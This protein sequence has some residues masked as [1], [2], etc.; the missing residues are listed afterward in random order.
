MRIK[1]CTKVAGEPHYTYFERCPDGEVY[2]RPYRGEPDTGAKL[3][4]IGPGSD[5]QLLNRV[6]EQSLTSAQKRINDL[7]I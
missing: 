2:V 1:G 3:L 5:Q 4:T 6:I 7:T